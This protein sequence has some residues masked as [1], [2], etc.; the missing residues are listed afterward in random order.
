MNAV[1]AGLGLAAKHGRLFLILGLLAG[2][3]LPGLAQAMKPWLR[4]LV[5]LLLF[6]AALRVGPGRLAGSLQRTLPAVLT[7][8]IY[9]LVLPL[10]A[11]GIA[12]AAG[13]AT[14]PAA[15][16][17]VLVLS[18]A[19]IAGSPNLA[20]LSGA[21]PAPAF[22]L[23]IVGTA[24]LPLTVIPVFHL[25]PALGRGAEV[26]LP[27]ARLLM[28]I[29]VAALAAF[30]L[31][32][33]VLVNPGPAGMAALDGASAL[34][35]AVVVVGLMSAIGPALRTAPDVLLGWLALA[36]VVNIGGQVL[37]AFA[38]GRCGVGHDLP[39]LAIV[40]GNRNIAL[41]LIAL[42]PSVTD[43]V[44]MFIGCYQIP[45]YTTP[46]LLSGFYRWMARG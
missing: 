11:V 8:L 34:A 4:D 14:T 7:V 12:H 17:V 19:S 35:M 43:Q 41:F 24:L 33:T 18:A 32:K 16:A 30:A 23:L 1:V 20:I 22:R 28:V 29:A 2:A 6:L 5:A 46:L 9:Q 36:F 10:L 31:R 38:L 44:L 15:L 3:L 37:A 21:D 26:L 27:A 40:A 42:P 25:M 39:S 45:M 13:I